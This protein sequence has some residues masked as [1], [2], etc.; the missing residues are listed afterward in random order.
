MMDAKK[1]VGFLDC[2]AMYCLVKDSLFRADEAPL[3]SLLFAVGKL[4][5]QT[6]ME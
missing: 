5:R 1:L 6:D 2:I 4:D 3:E